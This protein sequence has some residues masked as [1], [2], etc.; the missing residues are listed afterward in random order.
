MHVD[1]Q[2]LQINTSN[3]VRNLLCSPV[4]GAKGEMAKVLSGS[5]LGQRRESARKVMIRL[6]IYGHA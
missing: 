5:W 1:T 3:V 6:C 2:P 4:D